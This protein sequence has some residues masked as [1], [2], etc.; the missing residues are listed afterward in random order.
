M[1]ILS[2]QI[3][4]SPHCM[5]CRSTGIT[6]SMHNTLCLHVLAS[7]AKPVA[8][9]AGHCSPAMPSAAGKLLLDMLRVCCNLRCPTRA[10]PLADSSLGLGWRGR[11]W[12]R[13]W[14][15]AILTPALPVLKRPRCTAHEH[16]CRCWHSKL[17]YVQVQAA[18]CSLDDHRKHCRDTVARSQISRVGP[19]AQHTL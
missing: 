16:A 15:T 1:L 12:V 5:G 11:W 13:R 6:V 19:M 10:H 7:L 14:R 3:S 9:S 17:A 8:A 4:C 2:S 18:L